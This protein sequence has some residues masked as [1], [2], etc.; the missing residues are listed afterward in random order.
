MDRQLGVRFRSCKHIF[1][2]GSTFAV[3]TVK[4][5]SYLTNNAG[6]EEPL[7]Y[8]SLLATKSS[9]SQYQH[10]LCRICKVKEA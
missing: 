8:A 10:S 2:I 5:G 7:Y 4:P 9:K 1:R 3:S 6:R